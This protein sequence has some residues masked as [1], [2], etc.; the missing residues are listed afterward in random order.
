MSSNIAISGKYR[1][2]CV[3]I[4]VGLCC[5]ASVNCFGEN[6]ASAHFDLYKDQDLLAFLEKNDVVLSRVVSQCQHVTVNR[7]Q[8]HGLAH[9]E[10]TGFCLVKQNPPEDLDCA[11]YDVDASG[12]VDDALQATIRKITMTLV[13]SREGH[14]AVGRQSAQNPRN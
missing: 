4:M 2:A 1:V 7:Y 8:S 12:T 9:F 14:G 3:A 10:V 5:L 6:A 11:G 13:C